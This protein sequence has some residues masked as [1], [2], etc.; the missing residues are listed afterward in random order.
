MTD[1][2]SLLLMREEKMQIRCTLINRQIGVVLLAV[3]LLT[4]CAFSDL[5]DDLAEQKTLSFIEGSVI[6]EDFSTASPIVIGLISGDPQ[7]P[8]L[9]NHRVLNSPGSFTFS[10]PPDRYRIFAFIDANN[11]QHYQESE[12][13]SQFMNVDAVESGAKTEVNIVIKAKTVENLQE[14]ARK[15]KSKIKIAGHSKLVTPGTIID[16]D[17]TIFSEENIAMGLWQPLN[18]V[19]NIPFGLFFMA[20][21]DKKKI[22]VLYVHGVS[23]SPVEF[24]KLIDNLD[25]SKYQPCLFYFPSGFPISMIGGALKMAVDEAQVRY[26]FKKIVVIAHSMGG[27]VT[28]N[29]INS[30]HSKKMEYEIP[31]YITISTPWGGHDAAQMGLKYAPAVI[32]VWNDIAPGSTFLE[33]IL[34]S[35][36]PDDT[37]HYLLFGYQGE[38]SF[39]GGNSDGVVSI[40]SELRMEVQGQATLIRGF[41]ENHTSILRSK[42]AVSLVNAI[43]N[44]D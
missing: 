3:F 1:R 32:P 16:F 37:R 15:L 24:K 26:G 11:D 38:S 12:Y 8:T 6:L 9:V 7:H 13:L 40:A 41:D 14:Q 35:S 4:G 39:A 27:L 2:E 23:G 43:L 17:S 5:K 25:R 21:Y 28:R 22:P 30:L 19:K 33:N 36:L 42:E 29:Y 10:V 18:F 44:N 31:K 20:E 34:K